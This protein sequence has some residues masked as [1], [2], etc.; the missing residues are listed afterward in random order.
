MAKMREA[1]GGALQA[2]LLDNN[3]KEYW[4]EWSD[5][6][7]S[8][9]VNEKE[10]HA[11]EPRSFLELIK[12]RLDAYFDWHFGFF[13]SALRFNVLNNFHLER[14]RPGH[15]NWFLDSNRLG[16]FPRSQLI[17]RLMRACTFSRFR[18]V[19]GEIDSLVAQAGGVV[20][21][22]I[23]SPRLILYALAA[24]R[25]NIPCVAYIASWD[26]PVGKGIIY[27]FADRYIVQN[28]IMR[29]DLV[30]LHNISEKKIAVTG[31]LQT[32]VFSRNRSRAEYDEI[33]S[34]FGLDPTKKCVLITGNT[35]TNTPYEALFVERFLEWSQSGL[36]DT[37]FNV[38]FRPHPK[39][40]RWKSRFAAAIGVPG[41]YVQTP[42][43]TDIEVLSTLLQYCDCVVTHAGTILLDSLIN[44]RPVVC[45]VYD[46][47]APEHESFAA[48]NVTGKHYEVLMTSG[49]FHVAENFEDVTGYVK[50]SISNPE[51]LGAQR[52][53][54]VR[55][56]EC[57][58]DGKVGSRIVSEI[59]SILPEC[60]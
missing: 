52:K 30:R 19:P 29:R 42:G 3:I 39:D 11:E 56:V 48:K 32:D 5:S 17:F 4:R 44:D 60:R 38:I 28:E 15:S 10:L 40:V 47:G 16:L 57:E 41:V 13:P 53:A 20:I 14:L 34:S 18:Y 36:N 59:Q 2:V 1:Y 27:P 7:E 43:Y 46:E 25:R 51:E 31:W 55:K 12:A 35:E 24:R 37:E 33:I 45:V 22:N 23:Q 21:T 26:H 6:D 50:K 54:V 49:A 8:W 58:V 9:V